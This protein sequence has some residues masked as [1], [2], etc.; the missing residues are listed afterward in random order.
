[1]ISN[2]QIVHPYFNQR[3]CCL[4]NARLDLKSARN[5]K[6][7]GDVGGEVDDIRFWLDGRDITLADIGTTEEELLQLA[8]TGYMSEARACLEQ[9]R[10]MYGCSHPNLYLQK[11]KRNSREFW[12]HPNGFFLKLLVEAVFCLRPRHSHQDYIV[13]VREYLAK[14]NLSYA[15]IGTEEDELVRIGS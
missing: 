10:D 6:N 4:K 8:Q 14:A 9:A 3:D 5:H 12:K 2:G 1:M 13:S 15:D 11:V 7:Y